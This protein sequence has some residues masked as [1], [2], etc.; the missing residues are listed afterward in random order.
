MLPA[1]GAP[2]PGP[3]V[4]PPSLA[5]GSPT[6]WVPLV[7]GLPEL[8]T[9]PLFLAF[10]GTSPKPPGRG[11]RPLHPR[12]P[13]LVGLGFANVLGP[14]RGGVAGGGCSPPFKVSWGDTPHAPP[15]WGLRPSGPPFSHPR[16]LMVRQR[17]GSH[18]WR[19]CRGGCSPPF[20]VSWG[21]TPHSPLPGG[22]APWTPICP[23]SLALG[24]P[25]FRVPLVGGLTSPPKF[26]PFP[27]RE[28]GQGVR[29]ERHTPTPPEP[30]LPTL[31]GLGFASVLGPTRGGVA[32]GGCSPPFKVS[33]GDTP[34][35][36]RHGGFAPWTPIAH[37]RGL[38]VRRRLGS[39]S[40]AGC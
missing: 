13:T 19:G 37:P 34:H 10:G 1:R 7:A 35:A 8:A 24:S 30:P 15:P 38:R 18:S 21:D 39:H 26:S 36:P 32:G 3:L 5:L 22:S 9:R 27:R 17:F 40:R 14:T 23:P 33:W 25:E 6:F 31:V 4:F 2:P 20:K 11:L 16:G 29:S 12:L 28:G